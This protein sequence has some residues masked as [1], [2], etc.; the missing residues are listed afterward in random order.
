MTEPTQRLNKIQGLMRQVLHQPLRNILPKRVKSKLR[1]TEKLQ[2]LLE[3]P[4]DRLLHKSLMKLSET[5]KSA[6]VA[7][8]LFRRSLGELMP[9][10]FMDSV[11]AK[12]PKMVSQF[13]WR[14][15]HLNLMHHLQRHS[16]RLRRMFRKRNVM[17]CKRRNVLLKKLMAVVPSHMKDTL[18]PMIHDTLHVNM[19][20]PDWDQKPSID[21]GKPINFLAYE[22]TNLRKCVNKCVHFT[23]GS[24]TRRCCVDRCKND[25]VSAVRVYTRRKEARKLVMT[26]M[27]PIEV[28]RK[29]RSLTR[30]K[31]SIPLPR[32][33]RVRRFR[34]GKKGKTGK[35]GRWF[36]R[37][38]KGWNPSSGSFGKTNS[39]E[40]PFDS[41]SGSDGKTNSTQWLRRPRYLTIINTTK[42]TVIARDSSSETESQRFFDNQTKPTTAN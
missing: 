34:R 1:Y 42:I 25:Y 13:L 16:P 26:G 28:S 3:R 39:T 23:V 22:Q 27:A 17:N 38:A 29:Q 4:L 12:V 2:K 41:S 24:D 35:R 9:K 32:R 40:I 18:L 19:V 36:N 31:I 8:D 15:L 6:G 37:S 10:S 14:P 7:N 20:E 21:D 5:N 11:P 33:K 30:P